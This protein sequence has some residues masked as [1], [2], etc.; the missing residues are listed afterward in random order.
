MTFRR[1]AS[2]LHSINQFYNVDI[3]VFCEGGEAISY[4]AAISS[5]STDGTL[6]SLYWETVI[7]RYQTGK[8]YH[9]KS[10][11]S[12]SV[13]DKIADD[14]QNQNSDNVSVCMD[15][16]Y[17]RIRGVN[18]GRP[19]VAL[20]WGYSWENDVVSQ[21][22][23]GELLSNILGPGAAGL[24]ARQELA[25]HM[26]QLERDFPRWTEI[27]ISLCTRGKTAIFDRKK[28]ASSID[29]N[30]PPNLNDNILL[31]RLN[32]AGYTRKPRKVISVNCGEV[33]QICFGKLISRSV[34]H[35]FCKILKSTKSPKV[36]YELFM[37]L[38]IGETLKQAEAG[39]LNEYWDHMR[40]QRAAFI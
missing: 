31:N 3:V 12:K 7:E 34:Y 25:N 2:A 11:G 10:V 17:D 39:N 1:T 19:R 20:T 9:V 21:R 26:N 14:V 36:S 38:A 33:A 27:D 23:L 8:K 24:S 6:D 15:S 37:R 32:Q 35:I 28:P 22:V 13:L 16:D 4:S 29:I 5:T 40:L 30:N 18:C